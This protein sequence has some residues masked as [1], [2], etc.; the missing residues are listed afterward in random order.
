M[1]MEFEYSSGQVS[2]GRHLEISS[3][4]ASYC[5][6]NFDVRGGARTRKSVCSTSDA[7]YM[8]TMYLMAY[9]PHLYYCFIVCLTLVHFF[10]HIKIIFINLKLNHIWIYSNQEIYTKT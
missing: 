2:V 9:S 3:C 6:A 1:I 7:L 4:S 5:A 8:A 10:L